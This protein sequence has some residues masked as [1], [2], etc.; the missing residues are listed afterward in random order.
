[1]LR[2]GKCNH[3]DAYGVVNLLMY[4]PRMFVRI[5]SICAFISLICLV[6]ACSQGP[7]TN[8]ALDEVGTT[9]PKVLTPPTHTDIAP[10]TSTSV[11]TSAEIQQQTPIVSPSPV[12]SQDVENPAPTQLELVDEMCTPLA[13][14]PIEILPDII[15]DPYN[16]PPPGNDGRHMGVD[17]SYYHWQERSTIAGTSIQAAL[18]GKVVAVL[19][20]HIPYGFAIMIE[21]PIAVIPDAWLSGLGYKKGESLYLL[22]AHMEQKSNL[23]VGLEVACGDKLGIVGQTGGEGTPYAI[24]HLHLEARFGLPGKVFSDMGFYDT[25]L[26]DKSR[27]NYQLWRTSGEFRHFDPMILINNYLEGRKS[28]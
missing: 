13:G 15:S 20:N 3:H 7:V 8:L 23:Q 9:P 6:A 25:R 21:T 12:V 14:H 26:P 24:P 17:F 19:E 4:N 18:P 28:P 5:V 10:V 11:Q 2:R 1:L 22:Y 16:P 27:L